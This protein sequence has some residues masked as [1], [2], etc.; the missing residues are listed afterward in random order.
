[1]AAKDIGRKLKCKKCSTALTVTEAGL[2]VDGG[3][4]SKTSPV[5]AMIDDDE[6]DDA[7]LVKKKGKYERGLGGNPLAAVGGIPTVLFGFGVFLVVVFTSL[8][9][10]GI[11]GT[12]RATAYADKLSN[13]MKVKQDALTPKNKK[14]ADIT[15][16][17]RTKM[18]EDSDK[19]AEDYAKK[20]ND[21]KLDAEGTKI[22]NRRDVWMERYGLMFGFIFVSF[23]CIGYLRTE[24]PA[25]LKYVAGIIL[26]FMMMVMF[27]TFGVAGCAGRNPLG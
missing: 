18:R 19:I 15:D 9:I 6:G 21:A 24:Q 4:G 2:E 3:T 13:E 25:V 16:A 27:G 8:P 7:P 11:A 1:M 17:E 5:P 10:I 20:I 12:D 14:P 26:V 22:A 23:G